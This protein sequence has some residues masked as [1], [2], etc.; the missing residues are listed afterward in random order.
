MLIGMVHSYVL[1]DLQLRQWWI[2]YLFGA[3]PIH[4]DFSWYFEHGYTE[5]LKFLP[6]MAGRPVPDAEH[7][8][9][10]LLSLIVVIVTTVAFFKS[11]GAPETERT[12]SQEEM[13][14]RAK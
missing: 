8:V 4:L 12:V 5:T 14:S 7:I 10:Q 13:Q 9:Q 3:T 11:G 2:P 6:G 1:L